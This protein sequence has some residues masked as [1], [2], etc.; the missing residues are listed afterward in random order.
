M[1]KRTNFKRLLMLTTALFTLLITSCRKDPEVSLVNKAK[2]HQVKNAE[3]LQSLLNEGNYRG[4][5]GGLF[6]TGDLATPETGDAPNSESTGSRDYVDTNVQVSGVDEGDIIKTDGNEIYY[7]PQYTNNLLVFTVSDEGEIELKH[8]LVTDTYYIESMYLLSEYV[9]T[10]SYGGGFYGAYRT[11]D[12]TSEEVRGEG[13]ETAV[14]VMTPYFYGG[15]VTLY[16]RSN[17]TVSYTLDLNYYITDHRLINDS[18]FFIGN[19]F[20]YEGE[21]VPSYKV[22]EGEEVRLSYDEIY[23]FSDTLVQG[24]TVIGGLKV[25][26]NPAQ[27]TVSQKAYLTSS[28]WNRDIFVSHE[29]LYVLSPNYIYEHNAGSHES[30]QT[31]T[32]MQHALNVND[33]KTSFVAASTVVGATLNQFSSDE[34][35]GH[36][37]IAT[38]NQKSSWQM[39]LSGEYVQDSYEVKVTNYLY[40]LKANKS[41]NEFTL[42]GFLDEG[43]GKPGETIKSVRFEKDR[44]MIVTFLQTDP[45]Y[46]INLSD[47]SKPLVTD[48]I[49]LPGYDVYQHPWGDNNLLGFGYDADS[50]GFVRGMKLTAYD[51]TEGNAREI[52]TYKFIN[53]TTAGVGEYVYAWSE[54]LSNHHAMLVSPRHNIF[55]FPLHKSTYEY[56]DDGLVMKYE[57]AYYLF[58]IDFSSN[59]VIKSPFIIKHDLAATSYGYVNRAVMISD[60][61]FT[62][63]R[64]AVVTFN[65]TSEQVT[66]ELML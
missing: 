31:T 13:E 10:I 5:S 54:A 8:E 47:P 27:I 60:N 56:R 50:F 11:G 43:L 14:A 46:V 28:Y 42:V 66:S 41:Q 30:Y 40:I 24:M 7:V 35:N 44:A 51:I 22:N 18:L 19:K 15:R 45:L 37:R 17:F 3:K 49:E 61:I 55:G 65:L 64:Y 38:T 58:K 4:T 59:P 52:E 34:Y 20:L 63:S 26:T 57:S 6:E 9:M 33:A 16:E 21:F 62:F 36:F 1:L 48:A 2:I 29:N 39:R 32:I 23:Y 12:L 25:K 53:N